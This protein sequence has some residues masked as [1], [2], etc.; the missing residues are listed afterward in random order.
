MKPFRLFA[1]ALIS[2]SA[3]VAAQEGCEPVPA[4]WAGWSASTAMAGNLEPGVRSE[5]ALVPAGSLKLAATPGKEAVTGM[6]VGVAWF[7]VVRAGKVRIALD[8]GAWIDLVKDGA[9]VSS[10]GH[11]HGPKCS[12]IRK[13]VDFKLAPGRY[14]IQIVNAPKDGIG[15]MALLP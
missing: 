9:V 14:G 7:D 2:L 4:E 1:F 8:Q 12:G 15:V 11:G 13:I 5:M 6:Y 10:I 3:P